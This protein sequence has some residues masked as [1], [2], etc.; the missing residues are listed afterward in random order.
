MLAL[1]GAAETVHDFRALSGYRLDQLAQEHGLTLVYGVGI[2]RTF[3]D[4][5]EPLPYKARRRNVDDVAYLKHIVADL[6]PQP[7]SEIIAIGYSNGAHLLLRTVT[8]APGLLNGIAISG[9]CL[10]KGSP[11]PSQAVSMVQLAGTRDRLSPIDGGSPRFL[12]R[13][14]GPTISAD[15]TAQTIADIASAKLVERRSVPGAC[16]IDLSHW[17]GPRHHVWLYLAHKAGH[18]FPVPNAARVRLYG[19]KPAIDF[20][21]LALQHLGAIP[22]GETQGQQL[23]RTHSPTL[24][25]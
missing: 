19:R 7:R 16:P 10:A 22:Y 17:A 9:A 13:L 4:S 5:R 12:S 6:A 2:G 21:Y 25:P 8:E 11:A 18:T 20:P 15:A 1:H 24:R 23:R 3:N 14:I